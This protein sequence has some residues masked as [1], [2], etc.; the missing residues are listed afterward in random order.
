VEPVPWSILLA[1]L[2]AAYR[3][4][5]YLPMIGIGSLYSIHRHSLAFGRSWN[6]LNGI[7]LMSA[8]TDW[9]V[10]KM[11]NKYARWRS[12]SAGAAAAPIDPPAPGLSRPTVAATGGAG[13]AGACSPASVPPRRC[14]APV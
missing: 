10:S 14:L 7:D 5:A 13:G 12:F 3:R 4:E 1:F 6:G 8:S 11:A 2:I 9:S